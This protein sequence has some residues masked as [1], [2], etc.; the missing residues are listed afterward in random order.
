MQNIICK[1]KW[2]KA[3]QVINL[4]EGIAKKARIKAKN[5]I[6]EIKSYFNLADFRA[7]DLAFYE[8]KLV[9]EK[10]DIDQK[11]IK[12][13]Q[14]WRCNGLYFWLCFQDFIDLNSEK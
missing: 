9:K 7:W 3:E 2:L 6:E 13:F 12:I 5:E 4:I 1:I 10:Y 8:T 14:I 11:E